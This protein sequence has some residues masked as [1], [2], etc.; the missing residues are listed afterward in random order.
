M[1]Q[2][3]IAQTVAA[4][5]SGYN[6]KLKSIKV[7]KCEISEILLDLLYTNGL[8]GSYHANFSGLEF[9]VHCDWTIPLKM[10]MVSTPGQRIYMSYVQLRKSYRSCPLMLISTTHGIRTHA[11]ALEHRLGGEPL[12]M[13]HFGLVIQ[14]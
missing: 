12:V 4:L 10:N 8:I 13:V 14:N 5:N 2:A 3:Q 7:P 6:A 1:Q 11:Y 9:V